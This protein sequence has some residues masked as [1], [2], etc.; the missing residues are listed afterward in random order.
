MGS[1]LLTAAYGAFLWWFT[2]GAIMSVYG[3]SPGVVRAGFGLATLGLLAAGAG[4]LA[5][6]GGTAQLDVYIAVTG[7]VAIWGWQIASYYLGF[8]T[9]PQRARSAARPAT[10]RA[11]FALALQFSL[12][13]ELAALGG[14]AA[15]ALATLGQPNPW[16]LWMYLA[17]WL[18][19]TSAKLNVF[20][21]VRNFSIEMLPHSLRYLEIVLGRARSNS[22]FPIS[23]T[24]ALSVFI[25][26][27]YGT[28]APAS[29]PAHSTGALLVATMLGL[30][31]LEHGLLMLPLPA[32]LWG[33]GLRALPQDE[34]TMS[35]SVVEGQ[36]L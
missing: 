2:T 19:H 13:H 35:N 3:R 10:P 25:G 15:I 11:R 27:L 30:G 32:T 6:R 23:I 17:L 26:L 33:W 5:T 14:A 18:M 12:Y 4:V 28:I 16:A 31:I 22:L 29:D 1:P 7:A 9:G 20:L 8:I 34:D 36:T 24:V 21:G